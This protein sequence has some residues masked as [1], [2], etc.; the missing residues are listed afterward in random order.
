MSMGYCVLLADDHP[1]L[2]A[3][4]SAILTQS[5]ITEHI[6]LVEHASGIVAQLAR[7]PYDVLVTDYSMPD[8]QYG[9][10]LQMLGF[11]RRRYA[12]LPII[13]LTVI[14]NPALLRA[15]QRL[16]VMGIVSKKDPATLVT[17]AILTV[18]RGKPYL[19]PAIETTLREAAGLRGDA[20][21]SPLSKREV[22]VLRLYAE[23]LSV[24]EI[25]ERLR[26]SIKTVSGQKKSAFN[27][28]GVEHDA[29]LFRY[30]FDSGLC[31]TVTQSPG[32]R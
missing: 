1:L 19:S 32:V 20:G 25:A 15:L 7:I 2:L 18:L 16:G 3:G 4:V 17:S 14:D 8:P 26:R 29:E 10:G 6:G 23:G 27:K 12:K 13:V 9:D 5:G 28:L 31:S 11:L 21:A 24:T 30:A 22:E